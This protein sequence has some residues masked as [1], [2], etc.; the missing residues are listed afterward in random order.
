MEVGTILK[1]WSHSSVCNEI[2]KDS[3][4]SLANQQ[5]K[6]RPSSSWRF[7]QH[8]SSIMIIDQ[9][10]GVATFIVWSTVPYN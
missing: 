3:F 2:L 8:P 5:T 1:L 4:E 7:K 6:E 10:P 9:Y